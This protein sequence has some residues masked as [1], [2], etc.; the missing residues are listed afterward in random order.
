MI[1]EQAIGIYYRTEFTAQGQG[2][3]AT[4]RVT[5]LFPTL[6]LIVARPQAHKLPLAQ[7]AIRLI[8]C[9]TPTRTQMEGGREDCR[10]DIS[11]EAV[12]Q[13]MTTV[14]NTPTLRDKQAPTEM[15]IK[16][17]RGKG[18]E[19]G[20]GIK[21]APTQS[22]KKPS[23]KSII[24][25][26]ICDVL[27]G[28]SA[29]RL[30]TKF[31]IHPTNLPFYLQKCE[32]R[33]AIKFRDYSHSMRTLYGD[34]SHHWSGKCPDSDRPAHRWRGDA[35]IADPARQLSV[36]VRRVPR[37][38]SVRAVRSASAAIGSLSLLIRHGGRRQKAAEKKTLKK[39]KALRL[40]AENS[41]DVID[42]SDEEDSESE[43]EQAKSDDRVMLEEESKLSQLHSALVAVRFKSDNT[44]STLELAFGTRVRSF[45]RGTGIGSMTSIRAL[46]RLTT[47]TSGYRG[48]AR[49]EVRS[50]SRQRPGPGPITYRT[51]FTAQVFA[52]ASRSPRQEHITLVPTWN[53]SS[54]TANAEAHPPPPPLDCRRQAPA[55]AAPASR[56]CPQARSP[57]PRSPPASARRLPAAIPDARGA[58][59]RAEQ[60][61]IALED[62]L[63]AEI[64][65]LAARPAS[66]PLYGHGHEKDA[67]AM[68][69]SKA[70]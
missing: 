57:R 61:F 3:R 14:S 41:E 69:E 58:A 47:R 8:K 46:G 68:L 16:K 53:N 5:I 38:Q 12:E 30:P 13:H 11:S 67:E 32:Q 60:R 56:A 51:E 26:R 39:N 35:K 29:S 55:L 62:E 15:K 20:R 63:R 34:P 1:A 70:A 17:R 24:L 21:N 9:V 64:A 40:A 66:P 28:K 22:K 31:I 54:S 49:A 52:G 2:N 4:R 50:S 27:S 44:N 42:T 6:P 19:E 59:I 7:C 37:R 36:S 65:R 45:V 10:P 48:S 33:I 25:Q 18:K 43:E 23:R